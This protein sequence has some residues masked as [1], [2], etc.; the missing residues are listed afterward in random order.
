[1]QKKKGYTREDMMI[2]KNQVQSGDFV[3][4]KCCASI[5]TGEVDRRNLIKPPFLVTQHATILLMARP[6]NVVTPQ[7]TRVDS[8]TILTI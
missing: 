6:R 1:M 8:F 2:D 7:P 5:R 3:D 4:V